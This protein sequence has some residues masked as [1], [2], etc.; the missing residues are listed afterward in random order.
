MKITQASHYAIRLL[1]CL[2]AGDCAGSSKQMA[3]K[4]EVPF[5]HVAKIVQ[6]LVKGGILVTKKGKGGGIRLAKDPKKIKIRSVID[7]VEGPL[8]LSE[9][10]LSADICRFNKKCKFRTC[11]LGLY[12]KMDNMLSKTTIAELVSETCD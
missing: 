5:N 10:L 9:C 4:I 7:A 1:V 11:L 6:K 8:V 2:A 3:K 12:K